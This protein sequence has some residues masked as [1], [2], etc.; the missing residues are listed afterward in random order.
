MKDWKLAALITSA[1]VANQLV[2]F[3]FLAAVTALA[4]R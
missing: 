4:N 1:T 3:A 2:L